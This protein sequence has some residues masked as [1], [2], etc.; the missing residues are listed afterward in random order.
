MYF[1]AS[2]SFLSAVF[3]R[4]IHGMV[5]ISGSCLLLNIFLLCEVPLSVHSLTDGCL[6]QFGAIMNKSDMNTQAE[7]FSWAY[8]CLYFGYIPMSGM[9]QPWGRCI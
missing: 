9:A 2:G 1:L 5:C 8:F 6:D 3:L 7:V 4:F